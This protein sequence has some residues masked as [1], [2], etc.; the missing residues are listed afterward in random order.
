MQLKDMSCTHIT[1]EEDG[2]EEPCGM[3]FTDPGSLTRHRKMCHGYVPLHKDSVDRWVEKTKSGRPVMR[4]GGL[5]WRYEKK[6]PVPTGDDSDE[7][8]EDGSEHDRVPDRSRTPRLRTDQGNAKFIKSTHP[9][10]RPSNYKDWMNVGERQPNEWFEPFGAPLHADLFA[11]GVAA[12]PTQQD[13]DQDEDDDEESCH[14]GNCGNQNDVFGY[15]GDYMDTDYSW[16]SSSNSS[17]AGDYMAERQERQ[18]HAPQQPDN[19]AYLSNIYMAAPSIAPAP[20]SAVRTPQAPRFPT[21]YAGH[22]QAQ[23]Q[24][25]TSYL[26]RPQHAYQ[27]HEM[28]VQPM[29][30]LQR[31]AMDGQY[32]W[33]TIFPEM[34][35][36]YD[37]NEEKDNRHGA[38]GQQRIRGWFNVCI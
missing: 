15:P 30:R 32:F 20:V 9:D 2:G 34:P 11:D 36:V 29:G 16:P 7:D 6:T 1:T 25:Q 19:A 38:E 3:T 22:T 27:E 21:Q 28:I 31:Q 26:A 13:E 17:V 18:T 23:A 24:A 33:E 8:G 5:E 4:G 10:L 37:N 12:E 35:S 14:C